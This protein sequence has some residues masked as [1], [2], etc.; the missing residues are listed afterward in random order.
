[1]KKSLLSLAAVALTATFASAETVTFDF[2][3]ESYGLE[4]LSG[5]TSDYIDDGTSIENEGVTLTFKS[6]LGADSKNE[7]GSRLWSN[8]LRCY[9]GGTVVV[10]VEGG[11][12]ESVTFD[13][14]SA[15]SFALDEATWTI[16]YTPTSKNQ[17]IKTLTV[18]YSAG[19]STLKPADL[20][21]AMADVNIELGDDV[22]AN[23]LIN[24]YNLP[25]TWTSSDEAV[26][27]VAADGAVT[28]LGAGTTT[29]TAASEATDEYRAGKASYVLNVV[30]VTKANSLAE[31]K[32]LMGE[33]PAAE[34][35]INFPMTVTY[36]NAAYTYVTDG[37]E[38]SL[39]YAAPVDYEDLD[40]IPAGWVAKDGTYNQLPEIKAVGSMPAATEK[41]QFTPRNV[42]PDQVSL[43][44]INEVVI[45][46][47][48]TF[49]KATPEL[50]TSVVA[51]DI[52]FYNQFGVASVE[53]GEYDVKAA[54]STYKGAL[55]VYPIEY[56]MPT[57]VG[58]IAAEDAA[59][60][61]YNLQ[62]VRVANPENGLYIVVRGSK[63]SKVLVK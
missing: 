62:G 22:P 39:V 8:G 35:I 56:S 27:T 18:E 14:T 23:A 34:V 51:N 24:P 1:M 3:N 19:G 54:V 60:V 57:A 9:V 40:I 4:R 20:S 33:N 38:F 42:T 25:V 37:K 59:P 29:I 10:S 53:A 16:S 46:K 45:V 63:T 31:M 61:Y 2:V 13:S 12:I 48:V 58:G 30:K 55:Q 49:E 11:T 52:T 7:A 36:K 44:I 47:G 32:A 17:A 6:S 5:T 26:A 43:D 28:V 15:S 50:K 41:G 21:F